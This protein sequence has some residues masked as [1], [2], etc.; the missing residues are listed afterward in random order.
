MLLII[1]NNSINELQTKSHKIIDLSF[2]YEDVFL[3]IILFIIIL[4][5]IFWF[6][7]K[8]YY[9][10]ITSKEVKPYVLNSEVKSLYELFTEYK[11]LKKEFIELKETDNYYNCKEL[12]NELI[13]KLKK[14]FEILKNENIDNNKDVFKKFNEECI[15]LKNENIAIEKDMGKPK[16]EYMSLKYIYQGK[17]IEL[18]K[19]I[20]KCIEEMVKKY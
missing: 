4:L 7:Y 18:N 5:L 15:S 20:I 6:I 12:N 13:E 9:C 2:L 19:K 11:K 1:E 16:G 3:T 14:D 17:K 8:R 10:H